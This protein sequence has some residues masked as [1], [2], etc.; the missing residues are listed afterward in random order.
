M[1]TLD[2]HLAGRI[3]R[4]GFTV[5]L[6]LHTT[7]FLFLTTADPLI[8]GSPVPEP[9]LWIEFGT[10]VLWVVLCISLICRRLHDAGQSSWLLIVAVSP[11]GIPFLFLAP[12]TPG[13]NT[14]GDVP[15]DI[16]LSKQIYNP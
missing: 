14:Y 11:I 9:T 16:S 2:N 8:F 1:R 5:G 15:S 7:F 10:G 13:R 12:G 3:G 6:I 4:V